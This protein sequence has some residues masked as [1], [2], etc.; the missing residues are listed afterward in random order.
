MPEPI[1]PTVPPHTSWSEAHAEGPARAQQDGAGL[2]LAP[3]GG[4][5]TRVHGTERRDRTTPPPAAPALPVMRPGGMPTNELRVWARAQGFEVPDRGRVPREVW[6][7]WER[8]TEEAA[9]R[10]E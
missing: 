10:A 5:R 6:R 1:T 4:V 7:A 3:E 9:E 8:A 2:P